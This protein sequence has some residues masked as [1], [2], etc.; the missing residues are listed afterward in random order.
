LENTSV[1]FVKKKFLAVKLA[2][3]LSQIN[4]KIA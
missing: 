4:M 1:N 3:L 2:W